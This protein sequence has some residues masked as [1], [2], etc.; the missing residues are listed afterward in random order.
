MNVGIETIDGRMVGVIFLSGGRQT[1]RSKQKT[2]SDWGFEFR[3]GYWRPKGMM[4]KPTV[5]AST[6]VPPQIEAW[7]R[8]AESNAW[9]V[10]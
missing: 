1:G 4:E 8:F 6:G 9:C 10:S 5:F 3:H 7:K 2:L